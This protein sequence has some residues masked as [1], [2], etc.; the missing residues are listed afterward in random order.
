LLIIVFCRQS[1]PPHHPLFYLPI[2]IWNGVVT[3]WSVLVPSIA[4]VCWSGC[5]CD[6]LLVWSFQLIFV[7]QSGASDLASFV[8][9]RFR[10]MSLLLPPTFVH[11]NWPIFVVFVQ[12]PGNKKYIISNFSFNKPGRK[13]VLYYNKIV[14][15]KLSTVLMVQLIS[16]I[17]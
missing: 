2:L 10:S 3:I 8:Q 6:Y 14:L 5:R 11:M 12:A 1:Y 7:T 15:L 9:H 17:L 16:Y 4:A 13:F